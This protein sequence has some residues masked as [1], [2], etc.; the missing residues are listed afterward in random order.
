MGSLKELMDTPVILEER[1]PPLAKVTQTG[2]LSIRSAIRQAAEGFKTSWW[3]LSETSEMGEFMFSGLKIKTPWAFILLWMITFLV[4]FCF[5][6]CKLYLA[7]LQRDANKIKYRQPPRC[8]Q[9]NQNLFLKINFTTTALVHSVIGYLLMMAVMVFFQLLVAVVLGMML[10][11]FLFGIMQ[12]RVNMQCFC[13]C[14]PKCTKECDEA[15]GDRCNR[16]LCDTK[17]CKREM[18]KRLDEIEYK[19]SYHTRECRSHLLQ[20]MDEIELRQTDLQSDLFHYEGDR[21]TPM[22]LY[23]CSHESLPKLSS[24]HESLSIIVQKAESI[25]RVSSKPDLFESHPEYYYTC[26]EGHLHHYPEYCPQVM[27]TKVR[28]QSLT[29]PST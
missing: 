14:I 9:K 23:P 4:A 5:E 24:K 28:C 3:Q 27:M 6:V 19:R 21:R 12:L 11:Y 1:E 10:G 29:L 20:R 7:K 17:Q 13:G 25:P 15:G 8:K 22:E 2:L 16:N 26:D 18:L